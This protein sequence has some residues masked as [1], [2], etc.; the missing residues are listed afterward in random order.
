MKDGWLGRFAMTYVLIH[1]NSDYFSDEKRAM[2]HLA[3]AIK[4]LF[5]NR[6]NS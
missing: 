4:M 1:E 5:T 2:F 3:G 6:H